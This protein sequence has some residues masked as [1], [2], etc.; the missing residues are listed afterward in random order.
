[1]SS[2]PWLELALYS[3]PVIL[4]TI[5]SGR[6]MG[7]GPRGLWRFVALEACLALDSM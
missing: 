7:F 4:I 6:A 5:G 3:V 1:M 2:R